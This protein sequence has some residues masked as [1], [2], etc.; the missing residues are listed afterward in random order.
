M[1]GRTVNRP[2]LHLRNL[3]AKSNFQKACMKMDT[4]I[5]KIVLF[6]RPKRKQRNCFVALS[7]NGLKAVK[8]S[9]T[10]NYG[11]DD[12]LYFHSRSISS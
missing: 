8:T 6:E 5:I 11:I 2:L 9:R 7:A 1:R 10:Y 3:L 12:L 4:N